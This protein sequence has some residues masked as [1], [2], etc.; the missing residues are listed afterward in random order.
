MMEV[1]AKMADEEVRRIVRSDIKSLIIG[2][3]RVKMTGGGRYHKGSEYYEKL[4]DINRRD[5]E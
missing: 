2:Y 4:T 3:S 5:G 1:S